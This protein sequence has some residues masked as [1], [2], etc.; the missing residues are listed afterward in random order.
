MALNSTNR[1]NLGR[2]IKYLNKDFKS[3]RENLI[4][5][6][7]TYFPDTYTDFNESS[8]GMM[9]IEMASYLGDVLGYYIDDTLKE[10]LITT[11][12][13]VNSVINLSKFL[14]YKPKVTSPA[15]TKVSVYQLVPSKR[16]STGSGVDYEPDPFYYLRISEGMSIE[17]SRGISFRTTELVDFNDPT[18]REISI[19][20]RDSI[21]NHPTLYLVK[22]YVSAISAQLRTITQDFGQ[23][24]QQFSQIRIADKNVID[25]YDVR[26]SN[27]NKW[28]EVPYLAQE[29]VYVDYPNT[30][31]YDKDL[32]Q[33]KSSVSNILKLQK[34]SRR[35]TTEI[36]ENA[37]TI[38][39]FGG[40][41]ATN[42]ETLIP[43]LKNVGLGL[44]SSIN[45]LN[46]SYDPSN[47]LKTK[48]YGQAPTG[49]FTVSYLVGGGVQS[50]IEKNTLTKIEAISFDD[51][52]STF[53]PAQLS[54]YNFCKNSVAVD[55]EQPATGGKGADSI[56]EIR[57][58]ALAY[59]GS[60]NRAVTKND[61]QVRALSMPSKYGSIAKVYCS[62]DG[63]LDNNSPSSILSNPNS[64]Q[65]FTDLVSSLKEKNLTEDEIKKE[66][67]SFLVGKQSNSTEKNNPFAINLYT[68]GYDVNGYL[69][70]LNRAVKENLKTYLNEYRILT[71]GIN[72]LDGFIVNIGIDFDI[73]VYSGYNN[74]EV[75]TK[76]IREIT[77]YF[78]IDKWTFNMPINISE[79]E[80]IIAGVEG[81]QS[82][83]KCE[84]VNKCKGQYSNVSYN[85]SAATK[86]KMVY[87]SLDPSVFEVK[88]PNKDIKGRVV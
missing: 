83:P 8:P 43:N 60:Q 30:E 35:F 15:L 1:G 18:D 13:D 56:E 69:T 38:L 72:L 32:Q 14:G 46:E 80:L 84:I 79:L 59:F 40:G 5:Y 86:D 34:T 62:T 57:Q 24:P 9:F 7:K 52:I 20:E 23:T 71:D 28:Y 22:K 11:A 77:N 51:D 37:E 26:D 6:T 47:F 19:Y 73:R 48:S 63:E 65:E 78:S 21:D 76:C 67:N 53:N 2:D 36:N 3:F 4:N 64:L 12:E 58:N 39:V 25:I 88:Y 41:T 33:F 45:R 50:N 81:V 27:G 44:E 17:S 82:V 87:P 31:Q 74:R 42:E 85:I 68:L 49:V 61:Y 75:L 55:N 16:R 54:L 29:M 70:T 66:V 10:S